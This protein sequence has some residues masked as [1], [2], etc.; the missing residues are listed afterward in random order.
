M[1]GGFLSGT[2]TREDSSG[3]GRLSGPNPFGASKFTD[4]N[5]QV[6]AVLHDV[7][8]E[9]GGPVAQV[10]LAWVMAQPGVTATLIGARTRGQ[11]D[12]N[13]AAAEIMLSADQMARL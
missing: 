4:A 7:A 3:S 1:A 6:L 11:L 8:A 5:W 10:A 9:R 13:I 12:A 2:Y